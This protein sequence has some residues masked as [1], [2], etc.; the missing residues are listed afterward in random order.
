MT[1]NRRSR[2]ALLAVSV[3]IAAAAIAPTAANAAVTVVSVTG[4]DGNPVALGGTLNI[5]NMSPQLT[6]K[7]LGRQTT[8]A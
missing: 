3:A 6:N 2:R 4:D 8:T 7:C 1:S 5:R